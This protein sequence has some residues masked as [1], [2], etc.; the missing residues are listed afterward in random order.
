MAF[1]TK[2][3]L[4]LVSSKFVIVVYAGEHEGENL[5]K[6]CFEEGIEKESEKE[7][8]TVVEVERKK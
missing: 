3:Y 6:L 7:E 5:T 1:K 4:F 8:K 2:N